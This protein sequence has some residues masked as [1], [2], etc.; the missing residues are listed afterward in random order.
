MRS[1]RKL[2]LAL[3]TVLAGQ[4]ASSNAQETRVD[5]EVFLLE[6]ITVR[7]DKVSRSLRDTT[8]GTTIIDGEEAGKAKNADIDDVL[9]REANILANEG[10]SLPSIRGIDSTSGGRPS[11]TA[12]SQPRTPILVDDV[13]LP[14]NESS[15]ISQ[16]SLWDLSAVEVARGPQPTST[17]RN[18]IGGA[19]RVYTN[20]PSFET[21]SAVRTLYRNKDH[22]AYG[23]FMVNTPLLENELAVRLTGEGSYGQSY[24]DIEPAVP[25]GFDP[26][27]ETLGRLRGKLLYQPEVLRDLSVLLSINHVKS[28]QPTEG[29]VNDA[30][31]IRI[32]ADNQFG[33]VSSYQELTQTAYQL[34][35]TYDFDDRF[36]MVGRFAY[37]DNELEFVNSGDVI[38]FGIP[39]VLGKTA[40]EKS[41]A[42]G[43]VYL[44]FQDLGLIRNGVI[45]LIHNIEEE[46]ATNNGTPQ[47]AADGEIENT[48]IYSEVE[49]SAD[50]VVEGLTFIAGGRLE[51]DD[52]FRN[53]EAPVG[54]PAG[55]ADFE[56]VEFLPRLGFRYD[57][58]E[59]MSVGYSYTRGFRAGGLDVDLTAPIF[60][61]P[62]STSTFEPE[63]IDQHEI[64][65]RGTFLD[66]TLDVSATAFYH[67]WD[68]A[69]VDG[70]VRFL[71]GAVS[72]IGNVP[73][74]VGYGAEFS[75]TYAILPELSITGALGLLNTEITDA[76]PFLLAFEGASLPR[77]PDVTGSLGLNWNP[78]EP[79]SAALNV[80]HVSSTVSGLGQ[81]DLAAY[82]VTDISAAYR[83]VTEVGQFE[84]EGFVNNLFDKRFQTFSETSPLVN[85]S[86]AG[87]PRTVGIAL[88]ARW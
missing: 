23:A 29:L 28:E 75:A 43:E 6:P 32:T 38:N 12:G 16:T 64:Y 17:G 76:G 87:R 84:V 63:F 54:T 83:V 50:H 13:A 4:T 22:T 67:I 52:R 24:V 2:V 7:G 69:Q 81:P 78:V 10:F 46:D 65:T 1:K 53:T 74:A 26:E 49:L 57:V 42:E 15:A 36:S 19:I 25:A 58:N 68:N 79:L 31:N 86:A 88:N 80:R 34:R 73:E 62:L 30:R 60:G 77:A 85:L 37:L 35:S 55:R 11:I 40:F 51:I 39:F 5:T 66:G 61:L 8:A 71:N 72:L 21:E 20:D 18:A 33:L 82:T 14:S 59:E 56:E 48:G 45:G 44:Q 41:Q 47:F 3:A 9:E 70:A 27:D